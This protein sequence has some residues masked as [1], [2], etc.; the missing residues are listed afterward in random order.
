MSVVHQAIAAAA[1]ADAITGQALAW[2][3]T[4]AEWGHRGEI[5]AEHVHPSL[6]DA[7]RR[8]DA[9]GAETLRSGSVILRYSV[10]SA[11]VEAALAA[12]GP[13]ALWYHNVTPGDLLRDWNPGLAADCDRA[14]AALPR[15]R[16]RAAALV[17][18]SGFNAAELEEAG[19][20]GAAVVPLML[21][22][23]AAA[24]VPAD[25]AGPPS[26]VSVG[27]I[28]PN[29]RLEDVIKVFALYQR[30][31]APDARLTLVGDASGFEAYRDALQALAGRLGVRGLRMTGRLP[32]DARD[33]LYR[34]AH[35][36]LCMSVHEGFCAPL[37]ESMAHGVPVLARRAGAVAET[38]GG[39]GLVLDESLPVMAEALHEVVGGADTRRALR[40]GAARRLAELDPRRVAERVRTAVAPLLT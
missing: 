12:P 18:D 11:S 28:V 6:R 14:R 1:P 5:V 29:K 19:L 2:Q 24:A 38:V 26:I 40:A 17:A 22:L 20:P 30:H 4:L 10:W 35:A 39:G 33:A 21:D 8:L 13:L 36:Y 16:G 31:R 34:G 32:D 15:L 9:G 3:R 37:V 7:V 27:R 25:P 23:S